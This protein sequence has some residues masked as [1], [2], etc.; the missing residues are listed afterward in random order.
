MRR[1]TSIRLFDSVCRSIDN[2]TSGRLVD[3]VKMRRNVQEI[4]ENTDTTHTA[5][6]EDSCSLNNPNVFA[7]AN[8]TELTASIYTEWSK[9][10]QPSSHT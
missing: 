5:V 6:S 8:V 9:S 3:A 4:N 7:N 1:P 10:S 2:L